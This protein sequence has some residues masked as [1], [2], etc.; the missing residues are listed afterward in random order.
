MI[1]FR[2][3]LDLCI[4]PRILEAVENLIGPD[5]VL[6]SS[7]VFTKYPT[8]K[9]K[10]EKYSGDFVGWHQDMKYWG[11]VNLKPEGR[12]ELASMWLAIDQVRNSV[13]IDI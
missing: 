12:I 7:T 2:W 1:F 3:I 10:T 9:T 5:I 6:L 4:Q 11:L 13:S 8:E